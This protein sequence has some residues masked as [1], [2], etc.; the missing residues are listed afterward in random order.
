MVRLV[1]QEIEVE[2]VYDPMR[3]ALAGGGV[4]VQPRH[5]R[6][7]TPWLVQRGAERPPLRKEQ[8]PFSL[9][10]RFRL[11]SATRTSH[12][13]DLHYHGSLLMFQYL[14]RQFPQA[15]PAAN[16]TL[17]HNLSPS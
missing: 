1:R 5:Q 10:L 4:F 14:R 13:P 3:F 15:T 7:T 6:L 8:S 12:T 2:Q 16:V 9:S 11:H 17:R